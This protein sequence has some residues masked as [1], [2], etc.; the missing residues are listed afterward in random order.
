M[1]T[2]K[3]ILFA[4]SPNEV[5]YYLKQNNNKSILK[6]KEIEKKQ[7]TN[8]ESNMTFTSLFSN[9]LYLCKNLKLEED[10]AKD[11]INNDL[12]DFELNKLKSFM[13]DYNFNP[14]IN[15]KKMQN[16]IILNQINNELILFLSGYFNIN[17]MLYSFDSKLLKIYYLEEHFNK[18]KS[19]AIVIV[20]KDTITPNL[21][22]QS[23]IDNKCYYYDDEFI[24]DLMTNIYTIPIGLIENK[25]LSYDN[26]LDDNFIISKKEEQVLNFD[27]LFN[28]KKIEIADDL[29][30]NDLFTFMIPKYIK[31]LSK[32]TMINE[33][34]KYIT[35]FH[36]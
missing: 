30:I 35:P 7:F 15:V 29:E 3:D 18:L 1:I 27:E 11:I 23:I 25:L 24:T 10:N 33:I 32:E 13:D 34:K 36:I 6:I 21:G 26:N 2:I 8:F 31:K 22:Y 17:I 14:L 9:L 28:N 4:I 20:K 16:M 12:Y 5:N 19:C